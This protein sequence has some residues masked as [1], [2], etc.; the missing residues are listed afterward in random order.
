MEQTAFNHMTRGEAELEIKLAVANAGATIFKLNVDEASITLSIDI[1]SEPP[2]RKANYV[3][4]SPGL[5][6][7]GVHDMVRWI[8]RIT[9]RGINVS[10]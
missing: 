6:H 2:V 4:F 9:N 5:T 1:E 3:Q 10:R 8:N 7:V